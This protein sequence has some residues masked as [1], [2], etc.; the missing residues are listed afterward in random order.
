[1]L[2]QF[3]NSS[4]RITTTTELQFYQKQEEVKGHNPYFYKRK[5]HGPIIE[6]EVMSF[7]FH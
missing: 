6:I 5:E 7:L 2:I 3:S 1:M 4:S